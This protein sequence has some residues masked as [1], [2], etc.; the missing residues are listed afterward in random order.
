MVGVK[1]CGLSEPKTLAAAVDGG[2][3]HVGFVFFP[4][5]PRNL[6]FDQARALAARVPPHVKQVAVLVD[7]DNA[8]LDALLAAVPVD[9]LQLHRVTPERATEIRQRAGRELWCALAVRTAADLSVAGSFRGAADRLVYDAKTPKG[10]LP[11]GMGVRFDWRLLAG[12][13]HPLPWGLSGGLDADTLADAVA[14]T[15]A[16]LLDVSSG[17]ETAPGT[18]DVDKIRRFLQ[19]ARAL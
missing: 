19:A 10:G 13:A 1:I 16:R 14:V 4:P 5:S 3:S 18:K 12:F 8:L 2:A 9:I 15:G 11:G 6:S 17:V 7:P